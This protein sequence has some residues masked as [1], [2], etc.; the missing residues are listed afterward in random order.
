MR[1][2]SRG[3]SRLSADLSSPNHMWTGSPCAPCLANAS[4]TM[5]AAVLCYQSLCL[6]TCSAEPRDRPGVADDNDGGGSGARGQKDWLQW[7]VGTKENSVATW[8]DGEKMLDWTAGVCNWG[9]KDEGELGAAA[10]I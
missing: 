1:S 9:M 3:D 6:M 5:C 2:P 4:V 8:M 7:V 10:D